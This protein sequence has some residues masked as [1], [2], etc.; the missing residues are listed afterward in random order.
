MARDIIHNP[1]KNALIKDGWEITDDPYHIEYKDLRLSADLGAERAFAAQKDNEKIAI[2]IKSFIGQSAIQ[3]FK[4]AL[5]QYMLYLTYL[6]LVDPERSLYLAVSEKVFDELFTRESIQ[7]ARKRNQMSLIVV[8][9]ANEEI[10][11][12]IA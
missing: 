6:E 9:L 12:W 8:N 3:D 4:L 5:G 10:K 1:V 11:Q 7:F 2:E